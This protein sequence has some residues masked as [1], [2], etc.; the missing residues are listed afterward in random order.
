MLVAERNPVYDPRMMKYAI[1][2]MCLLVA[3]FGVLSCHQA[4]TRVPVDA[5]MDTMVALCI[6]TP[7]TVLYWVLNRVMGCDEDEEE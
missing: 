1:E 5:A 6:A 3:V 4:M 2:F 7:A